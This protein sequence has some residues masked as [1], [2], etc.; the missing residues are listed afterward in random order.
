MNRIKR[1]TDIN[2]NRLIRR[3]E[4]GEHGVAQVQEQQVQRML[5]QRQ[6]QRRVEATQALQWLKVWAQMATEAER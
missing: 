5:T 2:K 3:V 6:S 1:E 4:R